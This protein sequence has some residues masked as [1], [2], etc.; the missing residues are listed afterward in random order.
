L[1]S[2]LG[3]TK[4][5]T[6]SEIK[7]AYRRALL[8]HHPD[9]NQHV[10]STGGSLF[11]DRHPITLIRAAYSTLAD[12]QS[13]LLYNSHEQVAFKPSKEQRAAEVVSLDRFEMHRGVEDTDDYWLYPCRC[14]SSYRINEKQMNRDVHL[15]GCQ[16]CSEAVWVGYEAVD[17]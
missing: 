8:R 12:P 15:V 6:Q 9:K 14:G 1:Y 4:S 5:A 10:Q 11:S 16:G 3:V 13:R 2:V 17:E 7:A